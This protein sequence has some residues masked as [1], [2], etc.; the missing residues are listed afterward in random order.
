M[1]FFPEPMHSSQR[2]TLLVSERRCRYSAWKGRAGRTG[3]LPGPAPENHPRG[4]EKGLTNPPTVLGDA[5]P[6]IHSY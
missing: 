3:T 1:F 6:T 5:F 2:C 4:A